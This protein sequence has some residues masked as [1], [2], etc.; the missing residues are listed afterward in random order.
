MIFARSTRPRSDAS[1]RSSKRSPATSSTPR[2]SE[3]LTSARSKPRRIDID[4]ADAGGSCASVAAG[5]ELDAAGA[6]AGLSN[7]N[8]RCSSARPRA[9]TFTAD[10]LA[11]TSPANLG[12]SWSW[13]TLN[14]SR[15]TFPLKTGSSFPSGEHTYG[16]D[17]A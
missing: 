16:D 3:P 7:R 2:P 4:I 12:A 13:F 15:F 10:R 5:A 8:R 14:P 1:S 17:G 6:A 11:S 9:L